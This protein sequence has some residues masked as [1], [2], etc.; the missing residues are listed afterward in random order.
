MS[1]IAMLSFG[2]LAAPRNGYVLRCIMLAKRLQS[3][4]NNVTVYQFADHSGTVERD[5]LTIKSIEVAHEKPSK[6]L[7]KKFLGFAPFKE[8]WFPVDG[9]LKLRGL[10]KELAQYDAFY[11]ESCM[12]VSAMAAVKPLGKRIVLDTHCMNKDIALKIKQYDKLSGTIRAVIWH[13]IENGMT[14]RADINIA[15]SENDKA[16]MKKH[17]HV[18]EEKIQLIPHIVDPAMAE[19]H[20]RRAE[21]LRAEFSQGYQKIAAFMGDMGA[22]QNIESAR[23]IREVLAPATPEVHYILIGNN[24][25]HIPSKDNVTYTGFVDAFDPYIL[26]ADFCIAPMT[27]GSGVKTK[28]LDYLKYEKRVIATPVALEGIDRVA[29]VRECG[30]DDF[31]AAVKTEIKE[32]R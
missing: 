2:D 21:E 19:K 29:S 8:A 18:P 32:T 4:G 20:S 3:E 12:L 1:N 16:F 23:F 22:V 31:V 15:I 24:P 10:R 11:I 26:A 25:E 5:G 6:S 17:Y 7:L 14:K 13:I 28:V 27:I 9:Y 30:I